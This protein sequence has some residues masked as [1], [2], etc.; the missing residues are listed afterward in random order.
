M[1]INVTHTSRLVRMSPAISIADNPS[2][3]VNPGIELPPPPP[4]P[5]VLTT[6]QLVDTLEIDVV[7]SVNSTLTQ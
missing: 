6:K 2:N 3:A 4:D 5:V 1:V 7:A